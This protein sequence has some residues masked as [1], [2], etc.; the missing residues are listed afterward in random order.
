M[1][2]AAAVAAMCRAVGTEPVKLMRRTSGWLF[3]ASPTSE[4]YPCTTLSTP[5]GRP[6]SAA[7]S[8]SSEAVSGDHSAGL[9]TTVLPAARA[10]AT[11]QVA[12][13]SGAFQGVIST[14]GPA[15]SQVTWLVWPRV[16]KSSCSRVSSQPAKKRKLWATR[17]MT[18]RRWER[19][20]AP[21]STVSTLANSSTRLSMPSAMACRTRARSA[22]GVAAQSGKAALA[23]AT[24]APASVAVAREISPM[25]APSMGEASVKVRGE[26]T[27]WPPIQC[28]V[29][30]VTP[31]TVVRCALMACGS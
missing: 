8:A 20:S 18:P 21:L 31:A 30:T 1:R 6:A 25:G 17:G 15:G 7:M 10:G 22:R 24:A 19:S 12:S 29:S 28:R 2:F 16:A 5:A 11:F 4:P 14:H 27:R 26:A 13:I 23:A 9:S 3:R